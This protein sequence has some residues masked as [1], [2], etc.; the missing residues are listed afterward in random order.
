MVRGDRMRGRVAKTIPHYIYR[1]H[2]R[3][4][5]LTSDKGV[6]EK[7]INVL[8]NA[9]L[10]FLMIERVDNEA[11]ITSRERRYD[12]YNLSRASV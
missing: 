12:P 5:E 10:W 8:L 1:T 3:P 9:N 6:V 7:H 11:N 2:A 4:R